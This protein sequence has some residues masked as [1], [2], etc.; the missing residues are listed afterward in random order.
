MR[1]SLGPWS[2]RNSGA[3]CVVLI[4]FLILPGSGTGW[5]QNLWTEGGLAATPKV[6]LPPF[7]DLAEKLKPSVVNIS[8]TQVVR[9][10]SPPRGPSGESPFQGNPFEDLFRRFFGDIPQQEFKRQSLGSGFIINKDGYIVTNN[11][12]VEGASEIK[13]ILSDKQEYDAK[14]VGRDPKTDLALIKISSPQPLP[15]AHLGDSDKLR[16][17][18]WVMAIGNPFGLGHTVTTGIVSAKGRIIGAGPYDDFIQTDASINPGNSGGPLINMRGEIVGINTAIIAGGQGLGFATPVNLAKPILLQLRDKGSV[19]R[20]WLGVQIQAVTPDLAKSLGLSRP[21]GALVTEVS[22][23]GPAKKAGI[24]RGDI[25]VS[26]DGKAVEEIVELPRL[27]A[28]APVGKE[29]P[30]RILRKGKE[31]IFR[32][33]VAELKEERAGR[34][35]PAAPEF[36]MTVQDLTPDLARGLGL[37]RTRGV[38][39]TRV[40]PG[41]PADR[42]GIRQGDV[43][44]E[45]DE[46]EVPTVRDFWRVVR[47][48]GLDGTVLLLINRRG[49]HLFVAMNVTG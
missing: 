16:V 44:Q 47:E 11:H 35:V 22:E 46:Q 15:F 41:G 14:I 45:V 13:V 26:F 38:V 19:T 36:G 2:R 40:V 18:E 28:N 49:T 27:V 23:G 30:L 25:I 12:V 29:I 48:S 33:T 6:E 34:S 1:I 31:Q 24:L 20:G 32:V 17:G 43:V 10:E 42:A 8:T 9:G 39:V 5:G 4:L 37:S 3:L 21:Q 7:V